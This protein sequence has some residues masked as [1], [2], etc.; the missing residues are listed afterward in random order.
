MLNTNSHWCNKWGVFIN[1]V[2]SPNCDFTLSWLQ[3]DNYEI[4]LLE[5]YLAVSNIVGVKKKELTKLINNGF[6]NIQTTKD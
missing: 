6:V 5:I 4:S 2:C 3:I 1:S